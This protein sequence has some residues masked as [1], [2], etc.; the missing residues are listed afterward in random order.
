MRRTTLTLL[1]AGLL[2]AT[3]ACSSGTSDK[4]A[5]ATAEGAKASASAPN[6][7]APATD[8]AAALDAA[9][10]TAKLAKAGLP[11][12]LTVTYTAATDPNGKL[13]RPH[14]YVSKTAFDDSRVAD[15]PKAKE[16]ESGGRRDSISH[17]GT[18]ETFSTAEDAKAWADY[19]DHIGQAVG[20]LITPDYVFVKGATV[21]RVSHLLGAD[22]AKA[23]E[24]AIS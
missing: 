1:T 19:V 10:V 13:G 14:Q 20:G 7:V 18:V 17:G 23:Y 5:A 21:V 3:A 16:D 8:A 12:K 11:V 9:A 2:A 6:A 4:P 24:T 15:L 22:Q